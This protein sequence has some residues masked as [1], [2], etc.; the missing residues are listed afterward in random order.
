MFQKSRVKKPYADPLFVK[1]GEQAGYP[2]WNFYKY[3][4]DR[5]G[6]LVDSYSSFTSPN[7]KAF[8]EKIEGLLF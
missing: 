8:H 3:L 2:K 6:N 7:S 5:E 4:L 1:L